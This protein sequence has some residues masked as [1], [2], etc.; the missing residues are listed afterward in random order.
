MAYRYQFGAKG[1]DGRFELLGC[2][3]STPG[4]FQNKHV[5]TTAP[6]NF[7]FQAAK[8][9][10]HRH[11]HLVTWFNQRHQ[12]RLNRTA[13]G[14][15]H[16]QRPSVLG[17]EHTPVQRRGLLHVVAKLRVKLAQQL[18]GHGT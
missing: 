7:N 11:Q 13:G 9:A 5:G 4:R 18:V 2:K 10:K 3:H 15:V 17:L 14:T 8:P 12:G 1:F 6:C 16:H